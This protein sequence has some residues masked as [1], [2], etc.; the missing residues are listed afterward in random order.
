M[1][2]PNSDVEL[3]TLQNTKPPETTTE[4]L[5]DTQQKLASV[6]EDLNNIIDA[7]TNNQSMVSMA[8]NYWG[9][10][11]TWQKVAGGIMITI[12]TI[13]TGLFISVGALVTLSVSMTATGLILEDHYQHN[14]SLVERLKKGILSMADVLELTINALSLIEAQFA[15]EIKAFQT[16]NE[17]LKNNVQSLTDEMHSLKA[18][19]EV[20]A[21]TSVILKDSISNLEEEITKI[22]ANS[23]GQ[24]AVLAKTQQELLK[25]KNEYEVSQHQLSDKV[26]EIAQ[27][28]LSL[29]TELTKANKTVKILQQTVT[30]FTSSVTQRSN[31][32]EQLDLLC[33][34]QE[35]LEK[36][37]TNLSKTEQELKAVK[38]QLEERNQEYKA[39]LAQQQ[40]QSEQLDGIM[41]K[42]ASNNYQH[43]PS[44]PV[45]SNAAQL[46]SILGLYKN[47]D[48]VPMETSMQAEIRAC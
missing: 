20:F 28:K 16:E 42:L 2:L 47:S 9:G 35:N 41:K 10:L 34:G 5:Q 22:T 32:N 43:I 27:V 13:A 24:E 8:A 39:L 1:P 36:A 23:Q 25:V 29:Q 21:Q 3:E 44:R 26:Q 31:L 15:R 33:K 46:L 40:A 18:Q 7:I 30:N 6:K 14:A 37:T 19:L 38:D 48:Y 11:G 17:L 45:P 12:P 4:Q